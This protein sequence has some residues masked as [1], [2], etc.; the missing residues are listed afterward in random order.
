[1]AP[2]Q[3]NTE[4]KI[5]VNHFHG[6]CLVTAC[7]GA[8]KTRVITERVVQLIEKNVAPSSILCLTFTNKASNEMK[9]RVSSRVADK[10]SKIWISTFH[11]LCL[12]ILRKHG[13]HIGI[14]SGFSIF[15]EDDQYSMMEKSARVCDYV[16]FTKPDIFKLC[17]IVNDFRENLQTL[18]DYSDELTPVQVDVI[19]HYLS[20][21]RESN[22]IDFSGMLY[23]TWNLL[24]NNNNILSLIRN[25]FKFILEDEGQDANSIQYELLKLIAPPPD[26]NLFIVADLQQSVFGWRSA[27]PEN[28]LLFLSEY[29]NCDEI[30]LPRNY[31]SKS[32]ILLAAQSLIRNNHNGKNVELISERGPGGHVE[33]CTCHDPVDESY[34]LVNQIVNIKQNYGYSWNDFSV[35]YR[36]N[37]MSKTIES[38][39]RSYQIPY[40]IVGGFSF[41]DRTEIKGALSYLSFFVNP[42]NTIAFSKAISAQH[43]GVG[44]SII[45]KLEKTCQSQKISMLDAC[46]QSDLIK[47]I[48]SNARLHIE[49]FVNI[50]MQYKQQKEKTLSEIAWGIIKDTG[51]YDYIEHISKEDE[52][53]SKR[54]DN[55]N[56]LMAS[57]S[58]YENSFPGKTLSDYLHTMQVSGPD[59]E[60]DDEHDAVTLLTMHSAKGL[61]W[62]VV[63]IIGAE[64]G[65]IPHYRSVEEGNEEEERR[66]LYVAATRAKEF[67][68]ISYCNQRHKFNKYK[69]KTSSSYSSPSSFLSELNVP[70]LHCVKSA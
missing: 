33:I 16:N 13:H 43:C 3:L 8:G 17:N 2:V 68:Y 40:K 67:L 50:I 39:L 1:M 47:G 58:E 62:P 21:I 14:C 31:R 4:Q 19:Q 60:I 29:P 53:S 20:S 64:K 70:F 46:I 24:H 65:Y 44:K 55:L 54:I 63:F 6:P 23:E 18:D 37:Q 15:D 41:Y 35:L 32:E 9:D 22:S 42:W 7:P 30:I 26:G 12:A 25:R 56:E 57:I 59:D 11:N 5:A 36:V 45:G 48:P 10:S 49:K 61:E 27:K 69:G 52:D 51:Y 38:T 28:L 34:R 66:L